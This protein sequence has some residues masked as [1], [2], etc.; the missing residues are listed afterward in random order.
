MRGPPFGG[1]GRAPPG[2]FMGGKANRPNNRA[3]NKLSVTHNLADAFKITFS[4]RRKSDVGALL[5]TLF[6]LET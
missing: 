2:F 6:R 4:Y 5:A 1:S 3:R